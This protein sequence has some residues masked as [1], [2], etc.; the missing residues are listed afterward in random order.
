MI[1]HAV[2]APGDAE[3]FQDAYGP[4]LLSVL[5]YIAHIWGVHLQMGDVWFSLGRAPAPYTY[6]Q[7]WADHTYLID[8]DGRRASVYVD[9]RR[10]ASHDCGVRLITTPTGALLST[11]PIE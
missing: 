11:R 2:L 9:G 10:I 4:T 8:S 1:S 7:T 6:S 3:P 5:E